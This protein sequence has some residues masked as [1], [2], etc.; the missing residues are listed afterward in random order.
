[1]SN[2]KQVTLEGLIT[3]SLDENVG[4]SVEENCKLYVNAPVYP[5][6]LKLIYDLAMVCLEYN[7]NN[8]GPRECESSPAASTPTS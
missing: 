3:R 2:R 8:R 6:E 5:A 1:M 4:F 7:K